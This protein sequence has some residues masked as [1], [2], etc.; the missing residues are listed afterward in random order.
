MRVKKTGYR[1]CILIFQLCCC[2]CLW[3]QQFGG[4]PASVH[5]R[6]LK[7]DSLQI[8][9]PQGLDS[10]AQ[11]IA[12]IIQ[13]EQRWTSNHLGNRFRRIPI[14]LQNLTTNSNGYVGLGPFR[15]EYYLSPPVN[16]L[17]LGGV[18]WPTT[19]AL[20]EY[21]HVQQYNNFDR[22]WS[23]VIGKL[24][25]ENG[26]ALANAV[27]IP[28]WFFEGD[29]VYNETLHSPQGRG[30]LPAFMNAFPVMEKEGR[31]YSYQKLRNGSFRDFVPDHYQLGYLLV[32]YGYEKYGPDFW[33]KVTRDAAA[34]TSWFYPF[35]AAIR[36]NTG[37]S[38]KSFRKAAFENYQRRWS[39]L[40]WLD[41]TDRLNYSEKP[42]FIKEKGTQPRLHFLT[43]HA[44]KEDK[45]VDYK[46]PYDDGSGGVI[47]LRSDRDRTTRYI[48]YKEGHIVSLGVAPISRNDYYGY[49]GER[50]IYTCYHPDPRW[51][52]KEYSDLEVF[53]L[54]TRRRRR[55][56]HKQRYFTPDI[57]HNGRFILASR[58][59]TNGVS[60]LVLL[61]SLG[62][63]LYQWVAP[64]GHIYNYPKFTID[65]QRLVFFDRKPSGEM[66]IGEFSLPTAIDAAAMIESD[67]KR[68]DTTGANTVT[69]TP[70]ILLPYANRLLGF[71][72]VNGNKLLFTCSSQGADALWRLD[73]STGVPNA[74]AGKLE[75]LA[76]PVR[77]VYQATECPDGIIGSVF[78]SYGYQLV[79]LDEAN[80]VAQNGNGDSIETKA[81]FFSGGDT[82]ITANALSADTM[83]LMYSEFPAQTS[84][85]ILPREGKQDTSTT[86]HFESTPYPKF[87]HPFHFHSLQPNLEDPIYGLTLY[88]QNILNTVQTNLFYKYNRAEQST[89][90]GA[91]LVIGAWYLQPFIHMDYRFNNQ[92]A[93]AAGRTYNY[94]EWTTQL[95][96]Q[97]PLDFTGGRWSRNLYLSTALS[98]SHL[99]WQAPV[100]GNHLTSMRYLY[101]R[102]QLS[103]FSQQ[104][105][106]QIYPRLGGV[107]YGETNRAIDKKGGNGWLGKTTLY[108]P[109]LRPNHSLRAGL[110][111]QYRDTAGAYY[112]SS[113][114][115]F[116]RGY[117]RP[118]FPKM[119]K[120]SV[121][122][123]LPLFYPDWGFA[124]MCYFSRIRANLYYDQSYGYNRNANR[125]AF[126]SVGGALLADIRL[127]NQYPLT[128]GIRYNHLTNSSFKDK[129]NWELIL[130]IHLF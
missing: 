94:G 115:P 69:E 16:A 112:Y 75:K 122:Y 36:R 47:A 8:I 107:L 67:K 3:G 25:G 73:I 42:G 118:D 1:S 53:D 41:S 123:D 109:G 70:K 19:L 92:A 20:H 18:D 96:V 126:G 74:E 72:V 68:R 4:N 46:Y 35:Q 5:W 21:R 86:P 15:S 64:P 110:A 34:Y 12:G 124:S 108:L 129:N 52:E 38:F 6:Q 37:M 24:F 54:R 11:R 102:L 79:R 82:Q 98:E 55:L 27:A 30:R 57:A 26:Q 111:Y 91:D 87:T 128:I 59:Q 100:P 43:L 103:M 22:G 95:G 17:D 127:G 39:Q 121:D 66:A 113:N 48:R 29:A 88:G 71:P 119:W 31:A 117:L 105:I 80:R 130:P 33:G 50:L 65:D 85:I 23:R 77:G 63:Y 104:A 56:T 61:D 101:S 58:Q 89:A 84:R 93:D 83:V 51:S 10:T 97:L 14:V 13:K 76:A 106:A 49:N 28:D 116:S 62:H 40:L 32:A 99:F 114:F 81:S 45:V 44:S 9:F 90:V 2:V 78:T 120:F 7:T 60:A 125:N